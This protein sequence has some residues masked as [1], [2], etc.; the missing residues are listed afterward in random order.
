MSDPKEQIPIEKIRQLHSVLQAM[1]E[2][3]HK[4]LADY[5]A[6]G[7][8]ETTVKNWKTL[9]RGLVYVTRTT[10]QICGPASKIQT[11]DLEQ[12]PMPTSPKKAKRSAEKK[13]DLE[14]MDEAEA[15]L[16]EIRKRKPPSP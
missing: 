4:A 3:V 11:I 16:K 5:E 9:H 7:I 10:R 14:K 2:S 1:A 8:Q 13:A 15:K 12:L 6:A